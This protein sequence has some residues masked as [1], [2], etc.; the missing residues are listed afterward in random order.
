M[1]LAQYLVVRIGGSGLVAEQR[2]DP[3][4]RGTPL[5]RYEI[6]LDRREIR[7]GAL[8][9]LADDDDDAVGLG[10][11]LEAGGEIDRV[12]KHRVVEALIGAHVAG[13]ALAGVDADADV[14]MRRVDAAPRLGPVARLLRALLRL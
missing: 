10:L 4:C 8:R 3:R 14:E 6:E 2:E 12:A 1:A 11:R 9:L 5:H 13:D 7:D